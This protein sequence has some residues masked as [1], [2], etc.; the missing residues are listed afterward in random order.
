MLE[1]SAL[2]FP[3]VRRKILKHKR[4]TKKQNRRGW[5]FC[6]HF[7]FSVFG[8]RAPETQS[9]GRFLRDLPIKWLLED[10]HWPLTCFTGVLQEGN[11]LR[12]GI[13]YV[14]ILGRLITWHPLKVTLFKYLLSRSGKNRFSIHTRAQTAQLTAYPSAGR[15]SQWTQSLGRRRFPRCLMSLFLQLSVGLFWIRHI[16]LASITKLCSSYLSACHLLSSSFRAMPPSCIHFIWFSP[17][18]HTAMCSISLD[19]TPP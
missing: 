14:D 2:L 8:P 13:K 5:P 9:S 7:S 15:R 10:V 17:R 4:K 3:T 12:A 16:F 19:T 1:D 18:A 6:G 11:L